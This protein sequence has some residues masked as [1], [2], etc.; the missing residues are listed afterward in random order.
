MGVNAPQLQSFGIFDRNAIDARLISH[1]YEV[2]SGVFTA[3]GVTE[4]AEHSL[5]EDLVSTYGKTFHAWQYGREDFPYGTRQH[6]AAI[7]RR[8]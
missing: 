8:R 4:I 2:K 3:P 7:A 6:T 1:H 5:F